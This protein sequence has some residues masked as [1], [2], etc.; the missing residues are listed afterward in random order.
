MLVRYY[1]GTYSEDLVLDPP[2]GLTSAHSNSSAAASNTFGQPRTSTSSDMTTS[3]I[4][5]RTKSIPRVIREEIARGPAVPISQL[6]PD[7]ANVKLVP[8]SDDYARS[9]SPSKSMDIPPSDRQGSSNSGASE[10]QMRIMERSGVGLPSSLP[11]PSPLSSGIPAPQDNTSPG[12][13]ANSE[14][15]HYPDLQDDRTKRQT[16]LDQKP[17]E[18]GR[19]SLYPGGPSAQIPPERVPTPEGKAKI[20]GPMNGAPIPAGFKWRDTPS[21]S[22]ANSDRREKAKSR[23]FWGFGKGNS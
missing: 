16:S 23:S 14:L 2:S 17:K 9:S 1:T 13:R 3:P 20:S 8:T 12:A 11:D 5:P 21:D 15:G 4:G 19:K 10:V 18:D 7:P 22:S 6:P